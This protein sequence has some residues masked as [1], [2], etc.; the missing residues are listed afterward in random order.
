MSIQKIFKTE[1]IIKVLPEDTL[2]HALSLLSSSHDS[3]FVIEKNQ[4]LGIINPYYCIIKKSFPSNTKTKHC[5][6][7]P[8]FIDIDFPLK[9]VVQ[10]MIESK[11]HYLPVYSKKEFFGIISARRILSSIQ[12]TPELNIPIKTFLK[13]KHK[14][15]SVYEKDSLPQAL[16]MFKKHKISKLIVLSSDLKLKGMLAYYDLISYLANTKNT[17]KKHVKDGKKLPLS[18][19]YIKNFMKSTILTLTPENTLADAA[20][21]ILD[22][23]IGSVVV[24][25]KQ[26][27]PVGIITTRDLLSIYIKQ[28]TT[29][30]VEVLTKSLSEKSLRMVRPFVDQIVKR[31]NKQ[32][33][34]DGKPEKLKIVV[35][36]EGRGGIFKA[37][38]SIA[39]RNH[40]TIIKKEGKNL[41]KILNSI[42]E[43]TKK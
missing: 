35:K 6:I 9:K 21:M 16:A 11:I 15:I 36:E 3:A 2:A 18:N 26:R 24:V 5:L 41:L 31:L 29:S 39:R 13:S 8:P 27:H 14:I 30:S 43:K 7:H 10:L 37:F 38:I 20:K 25:D 40:I 33:N 1:N 23:K 34:K 17:K 19:Q 12:S 28:S 32:K 4:L 42:R 22:K